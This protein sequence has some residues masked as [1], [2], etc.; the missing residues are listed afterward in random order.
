[1]K[2]LLYGL[3]VLFMVACYTIGTIYPGTRLV[4]GPLTIV[5]LVLVSYYP[6]KLVMQRLK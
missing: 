6:A 4:T 3:A 1:M 5:F 2:K